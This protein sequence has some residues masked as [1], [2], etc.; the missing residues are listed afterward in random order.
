M[1]M[2]FKIQNYWQDYTSCNATGTSTSLSFCNKRRQKVLEKVIFP[3]STLRKI[4]GSFLSLIPSWIG[5]QWQNTKVFCG[6]SWLQWDK[7]W[8]KPIL[9]WSFT[10]TSCAITWE[11]TWSGIPTSSGLSSSFIFQTHIQLFFKLANVS[12]RKEA[13]WQMTLSSQ[14]NMLPLGSTTFLSY[15]SSF[16]YSW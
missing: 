4:K 3:R 6:H 13:A 9:R 10:R 8:G 2:Y 16:L 7:S 5:R 1:C 11:V 15:L 12:W 14:A